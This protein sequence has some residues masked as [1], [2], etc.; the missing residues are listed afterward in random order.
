VPDW[1]FGQGRRQ[2]RAAAATERSTGKSLARVLKSG[3]I[4]FRITKEQSAA[5]I[6]SVE[7]AAAAQGVTASNLRSANSRAMKPAAANLLKYLKRL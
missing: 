3:S 6:A 1:L 2:R 5:V 4:R 7:L